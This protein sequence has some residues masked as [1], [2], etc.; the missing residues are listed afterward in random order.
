[1]I[2]PTVGR[3][4]HYIPHISD[5]L[6]MPCTL[7]IP[8]ACILAGVQN[9][10]HINLCVFDMNGNPHSYQNVR[11]YQE[12]EELPVDGGYAVWMP[13]Q[14]AQVKLTDIS[15]SVKSLPLKKSIL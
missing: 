4:L 2:Q 13:Y 12:D 1:M 14:N 3:S 6:K 7:E 15:E 11:L 9:D 8:L 10:T 5:S